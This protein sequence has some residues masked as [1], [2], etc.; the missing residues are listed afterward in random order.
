MS[1]APNSTPKTHIERAVKQPNV[2]GARGFLVWLQAADPAA[3][4]AIKGQLRTLAND[5]KRAGLSGAFGDV[6]T[7]TFFGGPDAIPATTAPASAS[8]TDTVQKLLTAYAQYKLTDQ[9]L[10]AAKAV[11]QTNLQRAKDG[12][13]PLALDLAAM[14]VQ[15][16]GVEFGLDGDTGTLVKWG[17]LALLAILGLKAFTGRRA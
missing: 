6:G 2:S 9:Q 13:P 11:W 16:P 12:Q 5:N 17:G 8:W 3:Y 15:R 10:D 14:G 4:N 1:T 7:T